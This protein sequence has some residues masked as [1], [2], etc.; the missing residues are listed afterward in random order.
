MQKLFWKTKHGKTMAAAEKPFK[1][2]DDF[3]RFIL[4]TKEILSDIYILKRQVRAGRD[5]LDMVGVDQDNSA[6]IIENKNVSV[7]EE[8]LPQIM[9]YAIWAETHQ[10]TI[11]TWWLEATDRPDDLEID[12]D[13]LQIRL[14]VLAP[15]IKPTVPRLVKKLGLAVDLIEIRKFVVGSD[16]IIVVNQLELPVEEGRAI[17]KGMAVYNKEYYKERR[18]PRSVDAFFKLQA[19]L[20]RIVKSRGW[21]LESKIN[22]NYA[23][24]KCGSSNVF[25]VSWIGT[26][27]FEVYIKLPESK[28]TKAKRL[29]PYPSEYDGR[30]MGV[31]AT[32]DL[33]PKRLIPLLQFAYDSFVGEHPVD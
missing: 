4:N 6:V 13:H 26:K 30:W 19:E 29:C 22:A 7:D 16:E 2:E 9:R 27:S 8:I 5:I 21:N 18:N 14:T 17:A 24:F 31:R 28:F 1:T 11:K 12:W 32:E 23:C 20:E 3:E 33:K 15:S 10:D 25:G